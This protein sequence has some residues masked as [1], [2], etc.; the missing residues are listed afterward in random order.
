MK[1]RMTVL[2]IG[3]FLFHYGCADPQPSGQVVGIHLLGRTSDSLL[4]ELGENI[5]G[6]PDL[7]AVDDLPGARPHTR[8]LP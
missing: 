6:E 4:V 8:S 1:F 2:L 5:L 7:P 3:Q